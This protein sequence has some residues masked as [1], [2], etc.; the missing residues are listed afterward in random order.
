MAGPVTRK[1]K[2]LP[3]ASPEPLVSHQSPPTQTRRSETITLTREELATL[4][5]TQ[6]AEAMATYSERAS[7]PRSPQINNPLPSSLFPSIENNLV[8]EHRGP[9]G[10]MRNTEVQELTDGLDPSYDSWQLQIQSRFRDDPS[11]YISNA[12]RLDYMLRR[13]R[14]YAQIHMIAGMKDPNSPGFFNSSDEA[15]FSLRQAFVNPQALKEA[16][17]QFRTLAMLPTEEFVQ[18]RTRFLLL[19]HEAQLSIEQYRD[20][21]W[22]KI[23]PT[24]GIA[25]AAIEPQMD[26]YDTLSDSLLSIDINLRWLKRQ[27]LAQKRIPSTSSSL[28]SRNTTGKFL[29]PQIS[30]NFERSTLDRSTPFASIRPPS[31]TAPPN[32]R[33]PT[34]M[35]NPDHANDTC[36]T[37]NKVGHRSSFCPQRASTE[38]NEINEL[39][40]ELNEQDSEKDE[41]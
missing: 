37:C 6:I 23:T 19:A 30:S 27:E 22:E 15:L 41:L 28:R 39:E 26:T 20:E 10:P 29:S 33:S 5:S 24:L 9:Q 8:Q 21:L 32:H 4:I 13:T 38:L 40:E 18:F 1:G 3:P 31:R 11:W 34:P 35:A 36:F 12:R 14:G 25:A 7:P 17:K 2:E 16:K